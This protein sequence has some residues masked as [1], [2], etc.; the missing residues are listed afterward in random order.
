MNE[1][2]EW[3]SEL[4]DRVIE[5]T[6]VELKKKS[7]VWDLWENIKHTNI[8]IYISGGSRKK[9]DGREGCEYIWRSIIWEFPKAEKEIVSRSGKHRMSQIWWDIKY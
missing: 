6:Q 1:S 7:I 9:R 5:I 3:V 8:Y 4:E 2:E